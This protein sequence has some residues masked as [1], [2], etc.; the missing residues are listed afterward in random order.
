M[1]KK[2]S[3]IIPVYNIEENLLRRCV[4]SVVNQD[5]DN[6]EVILVDDGSDDETKNTCCLLYTS[7]SP[8]DS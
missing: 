2:V 3:I 8:R 1:S 6:L 5:Y 7:P 4:M